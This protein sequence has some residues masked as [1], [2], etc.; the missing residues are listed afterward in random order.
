MTPEQHSNVL[1][2]L[3]TGH[4]LAVAHAAETHLKYAGTRP[5]RHAAVDEDVRIISE[6]IAI[7]E[8]PASE[9]RAFLATPPE[10]SFGP[11]VFECHK[12]ALKWATADCVQPLH[13]PATAP[14]SP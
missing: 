8:Q 1:E 9:R 2:A 3:R 14:T 10:P 13:A 12:D 5:Q 6:A 7:M 11:W 4:E